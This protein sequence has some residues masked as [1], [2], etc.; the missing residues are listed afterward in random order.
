MGCFKSLNVTRHLEQGLRT[1]NDSLHFIG[2]IR[3]ALWADL[4]RERD[5]E[6]T[7]S[8]CHSKGLV[9]RCILCAVFNA[10]VRINLVVLSSVCPMRYV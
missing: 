8:T 2:V 1:D 10:Q 6:F 7:C 5:T 9:L 3:R 4:E